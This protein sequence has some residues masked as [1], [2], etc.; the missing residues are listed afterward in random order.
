[1]ATHSAASG[2]ANQEAARVLI[3][4]LL[5]PVPLPLQSQHH[6]TARSSP[7]R[8]GNRY[9]PA[10]HGAIFTLVKI[11]CCDVRR[12]LGDVGIRWSL[13]HEPEG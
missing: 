12:S 7:K 11:S 1:M 3:P 4:R 6:I 10:T 5:D 8:Y 2:H 9:E 13:P